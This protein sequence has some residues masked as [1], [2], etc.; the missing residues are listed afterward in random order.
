MAQNYLLKVTLLIRGIIN[1]CPFLGP[2]DSKLSMYSAINN[3]GRNQS[4]GYP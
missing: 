1:Y 2:F 3:F 4:S